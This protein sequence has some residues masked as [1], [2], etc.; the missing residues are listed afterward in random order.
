MNIQNNLLTRDNPTRFNRI[1]LWVNVLLLSGFI[2]YQLVVMISDDN[3]LNL[4]PVKQ[5]FYVLLVFTGLLYLV[6]RASKVNSTQFSPIFPFLFFVATLVFLFFSALWSLPPGSLTIS[7][8]WF[9]PWAEES[10]RFI[11]FLIFYD[12]LFYFLNSR[13]VSSGWNKVIAFIIAHVLFS[14]C[15]PVSLERFLYTWVGMGILASHLI[16]MENYLVPIIMHAFYNY[17]ILIYVNAIPLIIWF[18]I[19]LL[20]FLISVPFYVFLINKDSRI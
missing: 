19:L 18:V 10:M 7:A 4:N 6:L 12:I 2:I 15:H 14:L 9:A 5:I 20:P 1:N 13:G 3:P 16:L 8:I 11:Q 17:L